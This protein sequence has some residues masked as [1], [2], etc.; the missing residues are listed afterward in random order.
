LGKE[1]GDVHRLMDFPALVT[2]RHRRYLHDPVSIL[3]V[4][5]HDRD[6]LLA[7]LLHACTDRAC[8]NPRVKR[9]LEAVLHG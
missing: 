4:F 7:A 6:R 2:K 1:H 3:A 9:V 5:G 8:M